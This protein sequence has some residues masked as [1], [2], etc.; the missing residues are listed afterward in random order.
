[1]PS[2]TDPAPAAADEYFTGGFTTE[3]H[4][5]SRGGTVDAIQIEAF[6]A[7][8]RDTPENL[9]KYAAAIVSSALEYLSVHY[10]WVPTASVGATGRARAA[11]GDVLGVPATPVVRA[12][13][14]AA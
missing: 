11:R 9:D 7:G 6:R 2:P 8:A 12:M 4:G 10:G 3:R 13:R 5:S 1:M 14:R